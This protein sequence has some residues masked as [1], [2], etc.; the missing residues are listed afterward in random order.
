MINILCCVPQPVDATSFYRAVGPFAK[1]RRDFSEV[2]LIFTHKV[3]WTVVK[4]SDIVFMQR[5]FREADV[6]VA[7][8]AKR[9]RRPV[10]VDYDDDLLSV[11]P[12]NPTHAIYG[13]KQAMECVA[14]CIALADHVTVSTGFLK[15]RITKELPSGAALNEN[16]T[17]IPNAFDDDSFPMEPMEGELR[18]LV[19]WRGSTTHVKDLWEKRDAFVRLA[20]RRRDWAWC[21]IG[22]NP[23]FITEAMPPNS[24]VSYPAM[25]IMEYMWTLREKVMPAVIAVPLTDNEFNKSKSNIAM[26]EAAWAGATCLGPDW[27][28][29]SVPGA[30]LYDP[31]RFGSFMEMLD[32]LMDHGPEWLRRNALENTWKHVT[33]TL[34]LTGSNEVRMNVIRGLVDG[35]RH[36]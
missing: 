22:Y 6:Q 33:S 35:K 12:E 30:V 36:P 32:E 5:P 31:S 26:I 15:D 13:R 14:K 28:E 7:E 3:D 10:W 1:L 29:W 25:D 4:M 24:C 27:K 17:V 8:M 23:W 16:V 34:T 19:V 21:F 2:S 20:K 11:P 9:W 18:R